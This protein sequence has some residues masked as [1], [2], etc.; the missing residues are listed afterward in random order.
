MLVIDEGSMVPTSDLDQLRDIAQQAGAKIL[1][2][3]D[4]Q[5]L[6][7]PGSGGAMRQLVTDV[8]AYEL[9]EVTPDA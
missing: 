2:T 8:G 4:P 7:A 3:G 6:E 1:L 9:T 5:Q